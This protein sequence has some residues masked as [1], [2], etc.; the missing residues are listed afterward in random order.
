LL[1]KAF[2]SHPTPLVP[3]DYI[4]EFQSLSKVEAADGTTRFINDEQSRIN[5]YADE[6]SLK[7][8]AS[9]VPY[10]F[11][12]GATATPVAQLNWCPLQL[13]E[14]QS[15]CGL[16]VV[17]FTMSHHRSFNN[18]T[19]MGSDCTGFIFNHGAT[20]CKYREFFLTT[21]THFPFSYFRRCSCMDE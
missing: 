18:S 3:Q 2:P 5:V 21:N 13:M 12:S 15:V 16:T 1:T 8:L 17:P 10:L 11:Q 19:C 6:S 20:I 7:Y 4:R 14:A 9:T